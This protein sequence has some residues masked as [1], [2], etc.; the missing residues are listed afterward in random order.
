MKRLVL[1]LL[2]LLLVLVSVGVFVGL[3]LTGDRPEPRAGLSPSES[4]TQPSPTGPRPRRPARGNPF[5]VF[6]NP[7]QFDP[8]TR[9]G[10]AAELGAH[11][12]RSYPVLA[13]AWNG[14]CFDDCEEVSGAGLR[15]FLTIR[16]TASIQAPAA[17][18]TDL[19][20]FKDTVATAIE[21]FE[22]A[23]IAVENEE[24]VPGFFTGTSEQYL[25]E[26]E[27]ACEVAHRMDVLCSN[28]GLTG[29]SVTFLVYQHLVETG[30]LQKAQDFAQRTF[31][32]YQLRR[33]N[34]PDFDQFIVERVDYLKGFILNYKEAGADYINFH[35]YVGDPE[36]LADTVRY[37]EEATG[38]PA[39]TNELG[40]DT[41]DFDITNRLMQTLRDLDVRFAIWY[42]T[43]A[44][45][46]R[47]L[48]DRDGT[49]RPSGQAY[50]EFIRSH[51][52][53]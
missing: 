40:P 35:W 50:A 46:A 47:A 37:F 18:V 22:P 15:Y 23:I 17:P 48:V 36:A 11:Y 8:E 3:R 38:L 44:R 13:P 25:A 30:D 33:F 16:N 42:S 26:L 34:A 7:R 29:G 41:V 20:A 10:L 19:E 28:G 5:G 2:V 32:D 27:A 1:A 24:D 12:Y 9:V 53:G 14:E 21:V 52:A 4:P 51:F 39:V 43:D 31:E 6:F 45:I 49:L